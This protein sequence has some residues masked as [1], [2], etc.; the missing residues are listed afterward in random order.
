MCLLIPVSAKHFETAYLRGAAYMT[1]N[2]G[3]DIIIAN[4]DKSDRVGGILWQTISRDLL[5]E[6]VTGDKL[7]GYRQILVDQFIHPTL[8]LLLILTRRLTVKIKTH[9]ALLPLNMRIVR[10]LA[11]KH[12]DH[13]LVQ[14]MLRCM[15]WR[16]LLLIVVIKNGIHILTL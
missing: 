13:R 8:Y 9:L 3:A 1:A 16:K 14:Q 10:P 4:T 11:S 2:T 12:P 15:G 5:R 6:I 7:K